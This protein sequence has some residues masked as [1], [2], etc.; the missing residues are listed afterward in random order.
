[1]KTTETLLKTT[2]RAAPWLLSALALAAQSAL[3]QSDNSSS[4]QITITGSRI[5]SLSLLASSPVS[6]VG[7]EQIEL[8]RA[9]TVEDV[10]TKLPQLAGGVN[11]TSSGSDAFGAQT[12][13]L[14]NLGQNRTLVLINGTRAVPFSFRNAV[15]VNFIPATLV[16]R[17]DVLTGG[18]S[19]VYGADAMA[20]VVNFVMNDRFSGVQLG[21]SARSA[22]GGAQ[23]Y[24]GNLTVGTNLGE[25]GNLVGY[26]EVTRREDL[27]AGERS[28][29]LAGST[30]VAGA[31]GNYRDVASGRTFAIDNS[32]NFSTTR[33]TTDFTPQYT[34]VMP[35]SRTSAS[36]FFKHGLLANVEAFGRWMHSDVKTIGSP[37][38]GQAPV[39]VNQ[40]FQINQNNPFIPA[41]ARPLLTFVNG[42]A[43][44]NV[45]R[46]LAEQG[47]KS[48]ENNRKTQQLQAG[49]RGP[50]SDAVGW[51]IYAQQGSS[52][53]TITIL[54]DGTRVAFN[55][56]LVNSTNLFAPGGANLASVA[57]PFL[58]EKRQR[59]QNVAA[60]TLSGDSSDLFKLPAGPVGFALGVERRRESGDFVLPTDASQSFGVAAPTRPAQPP[61]ILAKEV[62]GELL[63]PLLAKLPGVKSLQLEAAY[64]RSDYERSGNNN[65]NSY[66]TD[67]L[68]LTWAVADAL[69]LRASQ[70]SVI[71]D[72]NFGEFANPQGSLAFSSLVT[73]ARLR[74]RYQGDPCALGTGNAAQCQRL[75][76]NLQPYNSLDPALLTGNYIFGGNPDIRAE[77]GKTNTFGLVFTPG[78]APGLQLT[79]DYYKIRITDA[80][81]VVQP[82]DALTSCYITDPRA[83]NPLCAAVTRDPATG[84]IKDGLPLDRNLALIEQEGVDIDARWR[85]NAPFGASGQALTLQYQLATVLDYS[86]Q[87]NAVLAPVDCKGTYGSRCSSDGVSLVAPAN[88]HRA[89]IGWQNA[90]LTAQLGL[91][92]IGAVVDSAVGSNGKI[93]AHNTF[94]LNLSWRTPIK[95]LTVNAGVD[96][97]TDKQP[98]TPVNPGTFNTFADTYDVVGRSYG[99]S[100]SMRF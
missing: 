51:E 56:S 62:Y 68:G 25:R 23:Q 19:A 52:D 32:G 74:P 84:R 5:K 63:L 46:S 65:N 94:D 21:A 59:T 18:A 100:A 50:I 92:R 86:I 13:D 47:V 93:G 26:F 69:M 12:L 17:V 3:A 34:L 39:V 76:P 33:Q 2:R 40:A 66:N 58:L 41:Q 97:L 30:P 14:R 20:G 43:N 72:P 96:N 79:A 67:K 49:L 73:V 98:P 31:G 88:K 15:D 99:V 22:K 78:F 71:R 82:V 61:Y 7:S 24:S 48:A 80:V 10:S 57:R 37:T 91:K 36:V 28:W 81:G 75:A 42:V 16:R 77:K 85:I 35:L 27:L 1:M 64:R 95:G 8:W 83:D 55:D 87:R 6:Q 53:E 4:T 44:V 38:A 89:A 70:Q 29:A 54:G 9:A 11:G 60:A 90:Q 45:E